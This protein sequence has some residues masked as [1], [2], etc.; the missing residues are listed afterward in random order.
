MSDIGSTGA[1]RARFVREAS[2]KEPSLV[3]VLVVIA[4]ACVFL[5]AAW[6]CFGAR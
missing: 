1:R 6:W 5:A 4:I 2:E 3:V